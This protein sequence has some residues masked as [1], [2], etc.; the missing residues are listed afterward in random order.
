[1]PRLIKQLADKCDG[2]VQTFILRILQEARMP[3]TDD[4]R[5]NRRK[6]ENWPLRGARSRSGPGSKTNEAAASARPFERF[7]PISLP[8]SLEDSLP[9]HFEQLCDGFAKTLRI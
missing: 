4:D 2:T 6:V 7:W 5:L 9:A 3:V 8:C 1:L